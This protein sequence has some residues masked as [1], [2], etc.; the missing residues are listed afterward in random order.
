MLKHT[1]MDTTMIMTTTMSI[2]TTMTMSIITTM[3]MTTNTVTH[4]ESI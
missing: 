1:S 2:I 3:T 4:M